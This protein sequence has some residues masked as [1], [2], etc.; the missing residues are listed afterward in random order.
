MSGKSRIVSLI[1]ILSLMNLVFTGCSG[2]TDKNL[3]FS[4]LIS[5]AEKYNGET[6]TLEVFYF[7]G[8]EIAAICE[9]VGPAKYDSGRLVPNGTLVW[10][11]KGVSEDIYNQMYV[12]NQTPSGY[13]EHI[14]K[15]KITGKFETGGQYGH[16][17]AY[18]YKIAF[19]AAELLEWAP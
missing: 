1:L 8:F 9:S 7:T 2:S 19:T 4:Q 13:P 14:G 15:L 10:V 17:N 16:M 5:Q 18:Q 12:Q 3:T 11:E 6:V